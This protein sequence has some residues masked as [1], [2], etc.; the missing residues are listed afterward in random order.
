[1]KNLMLCAALLGLAAPAFAAKPCEELKSEIAAK[2]D[3]KKVAGYKLEIVDTDKTGDRKVVGSCDG[4]KKK[5]VYE[6]GAAK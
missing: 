2:L 3:E 1:M 4:G 6:K 5:I